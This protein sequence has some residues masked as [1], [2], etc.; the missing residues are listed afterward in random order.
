MSAKGEGDKSNEGRTSE[1]AVHV[2]KT[3][4]GEGDGAE[5]KYSIASGGRTYLN[6][7]D[8]AEA[9]AKLRQILENEMD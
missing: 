4:R 6:G 9:L 8:L 3:T 7:G 5:V 1:A 2:E